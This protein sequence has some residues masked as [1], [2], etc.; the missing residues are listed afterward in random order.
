M[1]ML[2]I[3][4]LHMQ[5]F[6]IANISWGRSGICQHG[7][8]SGIAVIVASFVPAECPK[9]GGG[10]GH[11]G[12]IR[13]AL[14]KGYLE[15]PGSACC[16]DSLFEIFVFFGQCLC[17]LLAVFVAITHL[18][19]LLLMAH[20]S[21]IVFLC[22]RVQYLSGT[23]GLCQHGANSQFFGGFSGFGPMHQNFVP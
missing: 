18:T 3:F 8:F 6:C 23:S 19:A 20:I 1:S 13:K 5:D 15:H 16:T 12:Y 2:L 11:V 17:C 9:G 10:G 4:W 7:A 22:M 14:E 21:K